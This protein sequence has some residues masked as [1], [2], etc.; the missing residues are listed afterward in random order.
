[1]K[2]V[3]LVLVIILSGCSSDDL[4]IEDCGC[5]KENWHV[6]TGVTFD[7]NGLPHL[8]HTHVKDYTEPVICQDEVNFKSIGES[9]Y[10][11]IKCK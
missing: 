5:I 6:D 3:I 2:K 7:S 10:F 4:G 1:M 8:T 11:K 9:R